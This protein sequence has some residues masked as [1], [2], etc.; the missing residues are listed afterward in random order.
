MTRRSQFFILSD[1]PQCEDTMTRTKLIENF[2]WWTAMSLSR[3]MTKNT[4]WQWRWSRFAPC[5]HDGNE[6]R[7]RRHVLTFSSYFDKHHCQQTTTSTISTDDYRPT[8]LSHFDRQLCRRSIRKSKWVI[9][10][11]SF[12]KC[13]QDRNIDELFYENDSQKLVLPAVL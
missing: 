5:S 10:S 12:C 1:G 9:L 6:G 4:N 13:W 2:V 11:I 7:L 8:I 3:V